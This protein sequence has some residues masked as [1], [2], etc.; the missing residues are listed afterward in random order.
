LTEASWRSLQRVSSAMEYAWTC[1]ILAR[2]RE[3]N[4][5][6]A[7]LKVGLG[8]YI[9]LL[10]SQKGGSEIYIWTLEKEAFTLLIRHGR[11]EEN[12]SLI[13]RSP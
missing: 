11:F 7:R 4:K 9:C 8:C 2:K 3:I 6:W 13:E 12:N 1:A 10:A 5:L